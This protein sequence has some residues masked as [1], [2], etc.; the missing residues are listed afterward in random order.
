MA[1]GHDFGK[2]GGRAKRVE[3]EAAARAAASRIEASSAAIDSDRAV[4]ADDA[5]PDRCLGQVA[6]EGLQEGGNG[7]LERQAMCRRDRTDGD[8]V[9][10][11]IG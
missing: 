4:L 7:R 3:V 11:R 10:A 2:H 1:H 8:G 5:E 9:R 6:G